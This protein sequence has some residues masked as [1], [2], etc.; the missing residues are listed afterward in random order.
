MRSGAHLKSV[1]GSL[2]GD[3]SGVSEVLGDILLIIMSVVMLSAMA[4]QLI[5]VNPPSG[6]L[7]V[8]TS[9]SFDGANLTIEHIGGS[10][11]R[12]PDISIQVGRVGSPPALFDVASGH[13]DGLL[14]VGEVW[15]RDISSIAS[16]WD[17][18]RVVIIDKRSDRVLSEQEVE[19]A[20]DYTLLPDVGLTSNDISFL[21]YG[22]P[23]DDGAN[24]PMQGDIIR[25]NVTIHNYGKV[26]VE[27]IQVAA[28]VHMY[29]STALPQQTVPFLNASG[30]PGDTD[31]VGMNWTVTAWGP[32]T[33]YVRVIPLRNESLFTNNYASKQIRIGPGIV[34]PEAPDLNITAIYL[35]NS[36]P[37]HGDSVKFFVRIANQGGVPAGVSLTYWD[38]G[39]E[40]FTDHNISVS[41]GQLLEVYT[42]WIPSLGGMHSLRANVSVTTAPPDDANPGNNE[43]TENVEVLP[44]ILLVDDDRAGD[45]ALKDVTTSMRAALSA[46]GAQYTY[47]NVGGG[48]GP[49]YDAGPVK[50]RLMDFDLVIWLTGF[51]STLTLTAGDTQSLSRYLDAGG[52]LWL[53]GQDIVD[54]LR[55]SNATFLSS[56]LHVQG[57]ILNTGA[58]SPLEG[59]PGNTVTEGM[60][61]PMNLYPWTG[62]L[63]DRADTITPDASSIGALRNSTTNSKY[64]LMFN[65]TTN[66][67]GPTYT[68]ALFTFEL[69]ELESAN[70]RSV[71]TY[72]MLKWFDA[73]ARWGRDLAIS[74]QLIDKL[75][76]DFMDELNLT[77]Y[78][79]NNGPS[80][81]PAGSDR[82]IVL[83]LMN[84]VPIPPYRVY[85]DDVLQNASATT[86]PVEIPS[87]PGLGG[88]SKVTMKWVANKVGTHTLRV[89]VDP[90]N[91]IGEVDESNN[92]VWGT[93]SSQLMVRFSVLVVDD[94]DSPNNR[95]LGPGYNSTFELSRALDRLGYTVQK[96]VVGGPDEDGPSEPVLRKYNTVVWVTGQCAPGST[97]PLTPQDLT[98][99]RGYLSAGDGRGLWIIGQD[100]FESGSYADGTFVYDFL[101]I[102][103]VSRGQGVPETL[104]GVK[105]NPVGHG[106]NYTLERTFGPTSGGSTMVPRA[107]ASGVT[108]HN[109]SGGTLDAVGYESPA[110]GYKVLWCGW[111]LSFIAGRGGVDEG[112]YEAEFTYLAL[113][114]LGMPETRVELRVTEVD[115]Y[116]GNMTPVAEMHPSIGS[117]YVLKAEFH[118][119]G[120][121]RGDCSVRFLDGS[122][123]I[124][125]AF[126]SIAPGGSTLAEIIWTPLFAGQRVLT[127]L[128]DPDSVVREILRFNDA[129]SA[130]LQSYFFYDDMEN[131]TG[132]WKHES[133]ILRINGE[134]ALE[135]MDIGN[136]ST[137]V[138]SSWQTLAG[139]RQT[140]DDYHSMNSSFYMREP[141]PSLDL[142]L[143]FDTSNSMMGQ[144]LQDEK[145]AA[146]ELVQGLTNDSRVAIFRLAQNP[147]QRFLLGFTP[148]NPAGRATVVGTITNLSCQSYTPIWMAFGEGMEYAWSF[149]SPDRVPAVVAL[150]D[151]QDYQGSD[152]SIAMPPSYPSDYNNI[153]KGSN[154][155][156]INPG[157]CPWID[158]GTQATFQY[159]RGK[160][161]GRASVK[162]Y[163]YNQSFSGGGNTARGLLNAPVAVFTIGINLEHDPDLPYFST[164]SVAND[165]SR[166]GSVYTGPGS[167]ESGTPEYNLYR[168][169]TTS[170]R[171]RYFY[172]PSSSDLFGV[173]DDVAEE[174]ASLSLMRGGA[175]PSAPAAGAE[176]GPEG[177]ASGRSPNVPGSDDLY[178]VTRSFSL[179][180]VTSAKLSFWH[181][182]HITMGWSG[183]VVLVGTSPDNITFTYEY[184]TPTQSYTGN[185]RTTITRL[186]DLGREIRWCWNGVSGRG[187]FG[188]EYAEVNLNK[189]CSKQYVRVMF[190]YLRANGG[191]GRGWYLDDVEV[192]VSR[193]NLAPVETTSTDQ[194]ELV[195]KGDVLGGGG[196]TADAYSGEWAWLCH[197]P[198][199]SVDYL[200]GGL[201][202][203]LMTPPIDLTN[204]L[205]AQLICK[206]KFNI[207]F[208]EGRP[209]DGFRVEVSD[210]GG[211]SWRP[212]HFG[213]RAAWRV[214]GTDPAGP[215][216]KSFTGVD[217]GGGW[218]LSTSLARLNCDLT[219]WAGSVIHLRFRVVTRTDAV[220]H[221]ESLTGWGGFYVDDVTVFGNT[222]TGGRGAA[223]SD[224]AGDGSFGPT[225]SPPAKGGDGSSGGSPREGARESMEDA[226]PLTPPPMRP[227]EPWC[228]RSVEGGRRT[229]DGGDAR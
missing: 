168:I 24:A 153:E 92:E 139:F 214:S 207:N 227:V 29:V 154:G 136:V 123:V 28:S 65:A 130:S 97:D 76:P 72:E 48:D 77:V 85:I 173:F 177:A 169:A 190:A 52:K 23:V 150:C 165:F 1:R 206:F 25:I 4:V 188:W 105:G 215:D 88:V 119:I 8:E 141:G 212:V 111:D 89:A 157:F 79:R 27:N 138:A 53:I 33:V 113:H 220:N 193:S 42:V 164:V 197:N 35:S 71:L 64:G 132:H 66:S 73:L 15:R 6:T 22:E 226:G 102:E 45:G 218:V 210:D 224:G 185:I 204:A 54:D 133:T 55:V 163:W 151:G 104:Y 11:L 59:V 182:Y 223:G 183:A 198:S 94:D 209:P 13:P 2:A 189:Y 124:G 68:L 57:Y 5:S 69:S 31:T 44:T 82:V 40:L 213:V 84:N 109:R 140:Y 142:V 178:A 155:N 152:G 80:D 26:P 91:F 32:H 3:S 126:V 46:V 222:T 121:T 196:D 14:R 216:G 202:N 50:R 179:Q 62:G 120:G 171:G 221:Y 180:G 149:H 195:R 75:N 39:A 56:Y 144:P 131:G 170:P 125:A 172:A 96:H 160:Y 199:A 112:E 156:L 99:L 12:D 9:A 30:E 108:Y 41:A 184:V 201:D 225:V 186:D 159:H 58:L 122:T 10:D 51:E 117:S 16:P 127:V 148:L 63:S 100:A 101:H 17:R 194:W 229:L 18:V 43:R 174:L 128:M 87:L 175:E 187:T 20:I 86:N 146:L 49:R 37:Q 67:S 192:K 167:L 158:W 70:D 47:Y 81:E 95:A 135:Y 21:R 203:Y 129:A 134:S 90:F 38:S 176:A 219:G 228:A 137:S 116:Y 191:G 147:G 36:H 200:K 106:L 110:M 103:Q 211:V 7:S 118:N 74:E 34:T 83:F 61:L 114:W 181:K 217:I 143:V 208:T 60:T 162:G 161:F 98:A 19:R 78:V 166:D 107:D 145:N 205:D 93:S 115:I